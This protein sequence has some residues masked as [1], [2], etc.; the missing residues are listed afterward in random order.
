MRAGRPPGPRL[1][2]DPSTGQTPSFPAEGKA[3]A[4]QAGVGRP[5][6]G[7]ACAGVTRTRRRAPS[8]PPVAVGALGATPSGLVL[9]VQQDFLQVAVIDRHGGRDAAPAPVA[10]VQLHPGAWRT[11]RRACGICCPLR[12]P[13]AWRPPPAGAPR[14]PRTRTGRSPATPGRR[15][16]AW[17]PTG[18]AEASRPRRFLNTQ[19]SEEKGLDKSFRDLSS[20]KVCTIPAPLISTAAP[21]SDPDAPGT[22][23]CWSVFTPLR[24]RG[25][26]SA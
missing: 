7:S 8:H 25:T 15:A 16:G 22:P 5:L 24:A 18:P 13:H 1:Y 4:M 2:R 23:D 26:H 17:Q 11:H 20:L 10:E 21:H 14:R 3:P 19:L 12:S 9:G 6:W